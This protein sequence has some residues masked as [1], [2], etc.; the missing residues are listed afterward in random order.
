MDGQRRV[1]MRDIGSEM[2]ES[3]ELEQTMAQDSH[4][5]PDVA[6]AEG[7]DYGDR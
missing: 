6:E 7:I 5:V 4:D 2:A 3:E 1:A